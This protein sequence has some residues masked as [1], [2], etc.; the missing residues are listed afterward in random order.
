MDIEI[1]R[2]EERELERQGAIAKENRWHT[3]DEE[4]LRARKD[5]DY[6]CWYVTRNLPPDK[7][8]AGAEHHKRWDEHL[9]T[10]NDSR[11][12]RG[13]AGDNILILSPRGSAKSTRID[14]FVAWAIGTHALEGIALQILYA[15]A[16]QAIALAR[17]GII[18]DTLT[19]E[20]YRKV[21]PCI[22]KG[23]KW[24]DTYWTIDRKW[25][26]IDNTGG[27]DYTMLATG[28]TGSIV[29]KRTHLIIFDDIIK[30]P[31]DIASLKTREKI[32][33]KFHSVIKPTLLDGGRMICVG[34]RMRPDDIYCTDFTT[35][36][37]WKVIEQSA[38]IDD[39][40]GNLV[41]YW[42]DWWPTEKLKTLQREDPFGFSFQYQNVVVRV[43]GM[44]ID[45]SWILYKDI[46]LGTAFDSFAIG[47]D[48]AVSEKEKACYTVITLLG[49]RGDHFY[50]LDGR[51]GKWVSNLDKCEVILELYEEWDDGVTPWRVYI[52]DVAYQAS[53][54]MDFTQYI[55]NEK[56][57]YSM[58]VYG[59]KL[60]GDKLS[61]LLGMTGLFHNGLVY[62]NRYIDWSPWINELTQFGSVAYNDCV[63]SLALAFKGLGVRRRLETAM[64]EFHARN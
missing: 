64:E 4:I 7:S 25:A 52:E 47:I 41:S 19:G 40:S 59:I 16:S 5:F 13:I 53:L 2:A 12:L 63:D 1:A 61:H 20:E 62:F 21:F 26:G 42:P 10:G 35:E 18:K 33:T 57:L 8:L 45:P 28:I 49:K 29:G 23:N 15:S 38:L 55:H 17:S 3:D 30:S 22:R 32:Q 44:S 36:K 39:G 31:D 9:V 27:E 14:M 6:F 50:V 37:G 34:T 46:P 60:G 43:E 56:G 54:V 24:S 58:Q 11:H 48:L 51:R